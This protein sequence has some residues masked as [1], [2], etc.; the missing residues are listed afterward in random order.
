MD[1]GMNR[2]L[3]WKLLGSDLK[4]GLWYGCGLAFYLSLI[5]AVVYL[6][7]GSR[8]FAE[9]GVTLGQVVAFYLLGG[10]VGG[11]VFGLMRPYMTTWIRRTAVTFLIL[12]IVFLMLFS[13]VIPQQEQTFGNLVGLSSISAAVSAP[14]YAYIV[15]KTAE[16]VD[17]M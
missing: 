12:L 5:A 4:D 8:D 1:L 16:S 3:Y 6:L 14:I 2:R 15:T 17:K 7:G 9:M 10:I 11:M 13:V